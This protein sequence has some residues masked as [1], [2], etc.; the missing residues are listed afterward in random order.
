L[1]IH[2]KKILFETV[3]NSRFRFLALIGLWFCFVPA[4]NAQAQSGVLTLEECFAKSMATNES[5]AI[6]KEDIHIA[7]AHTLQAWGTVLPHVDVRASELLQDTQT[8]ASG[9]ESVGGTFTRRSRPEVAVTLRQPLFQGLREFQALKVAGAEKNRNTFQWDSA[10]Q[11]LL[12]DVTKAYYVVLELER[13]LS[14]LQSIRGTLGQRIHEMQTR[15]Q[16]GKS[17]ETELFTNRSQLSSSEAE[18]AK[19]RGDILAARQTL[20]FLIGQD[21]VT[22]RLK[23][24]FPVPAQTPPLTSFLQKKTDRPDIAAARENERLAKGQWKY[25]KGARLP[26]VDM[27]ANYYPYRVGFL[28]DIDWDVTF[29]LNLPVF[30]GGTTRGRIK[31]AKAAFQQSCLGHEETVR[32]SETEVKR[33]Y[34]NLVAAKSR[35]GALSRAEQLSGWNYGAQTKE[36]E[37][38]LV[39]NLDVIQSLSDWQSRRLEHNLSHFETKLAYLELLLAAGDM[40]PKELRR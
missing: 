32:R 26:R 17:R 29:N 15:I 2:E 38:G 18:I 1:P 12:G 5:L 34:Y 14:I 20:A 8:T 39:N 36:Y 7:E 21:E 9:D 23:D 28:S 27:E 19:T 22:E 35:E 16:V 31:E 33:A 24:D 10:R 37:L 4:H 40:P 30:Q 13:E 25:E 11:S 6:R 3:M